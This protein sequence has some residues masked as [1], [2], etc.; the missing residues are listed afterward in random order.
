MVLFFLLDIIN[1]ISDKTIYHKS[2]IFFLTN[3]HTRFYYYLRIATLI[4]YRTVSPWM[5]NNFIFNLLPTG[6]KCHK[7]VESLHKFTS[8]VIR[9]REA[10]FKDSDLANLDKDTEEDGTKK[11]KKLA[12]L[13]LLISAKKHKQSIDDDGIREEVDTFM[14]EVILKK[15][16]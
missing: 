1:A 5:Y 6:W 16:N 15:N 7:L 8:S 13:D 9:D 12:M 11:K 14:F 10:N 3:K 4:I 2:A